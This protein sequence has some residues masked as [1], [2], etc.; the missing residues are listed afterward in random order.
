MLGCSMSCSYH[1]DHFMGLFQTRLP[2]LMDLSSYEVE[3]VEDGDDAEDKPYVVSVVVKDS[4]GGKEARFK[5]HL[6]RKRVGPRKGALATA[7]IERC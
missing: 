6:K 7:M 2:E 1:L 5:F 3:G 4:S